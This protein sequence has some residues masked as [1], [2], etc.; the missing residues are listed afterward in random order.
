MRPTVPLIHTRVIMN[1]RRP[2]KSA[3]TEV[4]RRSCS[5]ADSASSPAA[6]EDGGDIADHVGSGALG[7]GMGLGETARGLG[8][9]SRPLDHHRDEGD[10]EHD[11]HHRHRPGVESQDRNGA[12][13]HDDDAQYAPVQVV[14]AVHE[15]PRERA[16]RR[17][18]LA[19]GVVDVPPVAKGQEPFK[20]A[21]DA[22]GEGAQGTLPLQPTAETKEHL[23]HNDQHAIGDD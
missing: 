23:A 16:Q 21:V 10:R 19:R 11:Q 12:Q 17:R 15:G 13:D 22:V 5:L 3:R 6:D 7:P 1:T 8:D 2:R 20:T 4:L 9:R 18:N 14:E